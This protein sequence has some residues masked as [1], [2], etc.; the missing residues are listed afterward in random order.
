ML[1]GS[2]SAGFAQWLFAAVVMGALL[3]GIFR[4]YR[5]AWLWARYLTTVLAGVV[6]AVVLLG[7]GLRKLPWLYVAVMVGGLVLP[8]GTVSVALGR[9]SA[10]RWFDLYCPKCGTPTSRGKDFLFRQAR[11]LKCSHVW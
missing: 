6:L 5:L 4:G 9:P 2:N 10:R 7:I 3:W 1:S 8:M 11:C